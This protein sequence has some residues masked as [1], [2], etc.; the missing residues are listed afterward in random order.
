VD[1]AKA[2]RLDCA[3]ENRRKP[4]RD[5]SANCNRHRRKASRAHGDFYDQCKHRPGDHVFTSG[6][7]GATTQ[8]SDD[9]ARNLATPLTFP[10]ACA[11][12]LQTSCHHCQKLQHASVARACRRHLGIFLQLVDTLADHAQRG[13]ISRRC[14]LRKRSEN[15]PHI[16]ILSK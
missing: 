10:T 14:A 9:L 7:L 1:L 5:A 15:L 4:T 12:L 3:G 6:F 2:P 8:Q 11:A 16:L 13:S